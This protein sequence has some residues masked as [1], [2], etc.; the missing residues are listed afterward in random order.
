MGRGDT[1][2]GERI[3]FEARSEEAYICAHMSATHPSAETPFEI[4]VRGRF[5]V[6][7]NFFRFS[8]EVPEITANLWRFAQAAYLDNPLPSLFKERLF[9][10]LSRFCEVRYCVARHVGFLTGRGRPA[11]DAKARTQTVE[12]IVRLL[13]RT[14][15]RGKQLESVLSLAHNHAPLG[16][17]A[18]TASDVE[19]ALFAITSHVF[20]QTPGASACFEALKALLDPVRLQYLV[21]LLMFIRSA[22]YWTIVHP[23]LAFE[24][25]IQQLL[26]THE[27]LADCILRDPEAMGLKAIADAT[28][29]L[30]ESQ[31]LLRMAAQA[32]RMMAY[33]WDAQ[34]D[35]L[36]RSDGVAQILGEDEKTH[37]TG[38]QI[39]AM[40]PAEDRERLNVAIAQLT[41]EKP[42]LQIR[43]RMVRSD[44]NVIWVDRC[45]R[46][47]F[48]EHGKILRI[49]GM[50]ADVTDRVRA[51]EALA[52]VSRQLIESQERE[53][54]RIARELHDDINQRLALL[55]VEMERVEENPSE[56]PKRIREFRERTIEI[57]RDLQAL[58]HELHS[59]KLEYLG[60]VAAMKSWCREFA[61]QQKLQIH[62]HGDT[63]KILPVE[64]GLCLFR[65]LQ[66][67]LHNSVKHSGTK[68]ID[69]QLGDHAND[70][71]LTITDSGGG[72]DVES[73]KSCRGVGLVSMQERVRLVH[74]TI[75]IQ[76]KPSAGTTVRIRLPVE[77]GKVFKRGAT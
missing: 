63:S 45:S 74:G 10:Y 20:L 4:E 22:H 44:G 17:F 15:P 40:I 32:G 2:W 29:A 67:A 7:P 14:L 37:T 26:T 39:L 27:D 66:E 28:V 56:A 51:G 55:A 47:Y 69:V 19:E 34:T 11:G 24:E 3:S 60:A 50:I 68:Q 41:P 1:E 77:S 18:D 61:E 46:A 12:E 71:E 25:D 52:S 57:S 33:E 54:T 43:Y 8:P 36:V 59:S 48:D 35:K 13:K 21:L 6:L 42:Y 38:E 49:V 58:S 23:E 64:V 9:V 75:E 76:S 65:V 30:S 73:V 72:F 62:F 53:R 31:D 5:G 70:V 16:E